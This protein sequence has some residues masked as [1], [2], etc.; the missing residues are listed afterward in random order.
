MGQKQHK[1]K[2]HHSYSEEEE[3][4]EEEKEEKKEKKKESINEKEKNDIDN[5]NNNKEDDN[6]S[7]DY[8]YENIIKALKH[9]NLSEQEVEDNYDF[10]ITNY[11]KFKKINKIINNVKIAKLYNLTPF[12]ILAKLVPENKL[13][14]LPSDYDSSE[15]KK[16]IF[17]ESPINP[18]YVLPSKWEDLFDLEI[19]DKAL[20]K[21]YISSEIQKVLKN[22]SE[23]KGESCEKWEKRINEDNYEIFEIELKNFYNNYKD[24]DKI[25]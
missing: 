18:E 15:N 20:D 23:W 3:E 5:E 19:S 25:L 13:K 22:Y 11:E 7:E 14:N 24:K 9:M 1:A 21:L 10:Y 8:T 17:N 16:E 6:T 2:R 4:K 12:E